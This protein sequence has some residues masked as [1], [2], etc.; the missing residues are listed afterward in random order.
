MKNIIYIEEKCIRCGSCAQ[1]SEYGGVKIENGKIIF[2]TSKNED[3]NLII[4]ICPTGAL[5]I[6]KF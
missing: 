6:R 5:L 3:W 2:D 4:Q 1:E